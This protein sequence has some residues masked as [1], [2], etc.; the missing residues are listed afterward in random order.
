MPT[1]LLV[2]DD[3]I[4]SPMLA[5]TVEMLRGLGTVRVAA[6]AS[7]QSWKAKAITRFGKVEVRSHDGFGV[8]GFAVK[9]TPSDCVNLGV[10]SLF[11]DPPDWV[12]SGINIGDNVG[13]AFVMNSGT[14][15]AAI[16]AA[17]LGIPA[18]AFSHHLADPLYRQWSTEG[19]LTGAEAE[20]AVGSAA[21]AVGRL[22][23]T[24]LKHGLPEN[25]M[26][27]NINF[28]HGV[29]ADTPVRWTQPQIN[30]YGA[31]F[32]KDGDGY[33]HRYRGDAWREPSENNDRDVVEGGEISVSALTLRNLSLTGFAPYSFE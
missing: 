21:A 16:E 13:L 27:L 25:A 10:H 8:E 2:N 30:S 29:R 9:G 28:P 3:G 23:P 24:I 32:E 12:V 26:M 14:V 7:E 19:R 17:L 31:L 5:P 4:D 20:A 33:R 1:F 15:G 6:P 18:V 11:G 22:M